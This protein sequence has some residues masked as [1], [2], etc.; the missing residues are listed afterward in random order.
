MPESAETTA[1]APDAT[2]TGEA[3]RIR[4]APNG[5]VTVQCDDPDATRRFIDAA[6]GGKVTVT[7]VPKVAAVAEAQAEGTVNGM[8][9]TPPATATVPAPAAAN[10]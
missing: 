7:F 3:C 1:P 8:P 9:A 6:M 10:G 2:P 5:E 4:F